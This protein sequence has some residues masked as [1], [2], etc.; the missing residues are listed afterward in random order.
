MAVA[1]VTDRGRGWGWPSLR[2]P[3]AGGGGGG[4]R[5]HGYRCRQVLYKT[6]L[7]RTS[8]FDFTIRFLMFTTSQISAVHLFFD[9]YLRLHSP[10]M[11]AAFGRPATLTGAT[12]AYTEEIRNYVRA[13]PSPIN[14]LGSFSDECIKI[15]LDK[16]F[17][18]VGTN[19][20][21]ELSETAWKCCVCLGVPR[22]PASLTRCG[23]AGCEKC[24]RQILVTAPP[25]DASPGSRMP[26]GVKPCPVCRTPFIKDEILEYAKWPLFSKQI[27]A[28]MRAKCENCDFES[29]LISTVRHERNS[30]QQRRVVCAGCPFTG[31]LQ[32]TI[33]HALQ[34]NEVKVFC[35]Q[36]AYP[37]RFM[38]RAKHNCHSFLYHLRRHADAPIAPGRPCAVSNSIV[39]AD[40]WE[41]LFWDAEDLSWSPADSPQSDVL[42][43]GTINVAT[44]PTASTQMPGYPT[45]SDVARLHRNNQ[46][47][48]PPGR[49]TRGGH[50]DGG[51]GPIRGPYRGVR[52][53]NIFDH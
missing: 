6:S 25:I 53:R 18:S 12:T 48:T 38:E 4:G 35:Y 34:C 49:S 22:D 16:S 26:I 42:D 24:F 41:T 1:T 40:D 50:Q 31:Q 2:L 14:S 23:H 36:C 39:S 51:G 15:P 20:P 17:L 21:V 30:C 13:H 7:T 43:L 29:D 45:L 5:R 44:P 19:Q 8:F 10:L 27:W 32:E 47:N 46:E 11:Q 37:I 3:I 52:A 28:Q 33:D 9:F